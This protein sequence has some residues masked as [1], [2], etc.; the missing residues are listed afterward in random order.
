R[1][2]GTCVIRGCV[3]KKMMVYASEYTH[4][5]ETM[6]KYGWE[7]KDPS[8]NWNLFKEN[9]DNEISRLS[10]IYQKLLGNN[11]VNVLEG[12]GRIVSAHEV[13]VNGKIYSAENILIAV[14]GKPNLPQIEGIDLA[15]TSNEIFHLDK[16]PEKLLIVGAGFIAVEFAC[17]FKGLG[18]DVSVVFRRPKV[19]RGF[20]EDCAKFLMGELERKG[21]N[22]IR[23]DVIEKLEKRD[24][25]I[26]A[27]S[28]GLGEISADCVLYATG[29]IPMTNDLGLENVD[30]KTQKNGAIVVDDKMK[31]CVDS[32]YAVGDVIDKANLTPV[33]TCQGTLLAENLFN[34]KDQSMDYS[35]IPSAIFTSPPFATVGLNEEEASEKF[36]NIDVY[37]SEFRALKYTLDSNGERT[38]CKLIVNP[39]DDRVLGVHMVGKDAAEIMQ[40]M[41]IAIKAGATKADFDKTIGIHPSSA[42]EFVT[43]RSKRD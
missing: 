39:V 18:S 27:H 40:G 19:L 2:G 5:I 13:E 35:A 37:T 21:I 23:E 41:A 15:I 43:L 10:G 20:D 34:G 4:E 30:V 42:E 7:S 6:S 1:Y 11:G 33:A 28:A 29:R 31:T 32:I 36:K 8:L 26:I 17:I 24:G 3:P 38:F 22:L 16:V 25:N 12:R 14:G 9:R